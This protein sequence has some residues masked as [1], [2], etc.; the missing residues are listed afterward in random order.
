M[1]ENNTTIKARGSALIPLLVFVAVYLGA[2][3]VLNAMGVDMAF[4]QFPSPVAAMIGVVVAFIMFKGT[5]NEKF[6][7]FAKGCGHEDILTM[8][9][10]YLFA[11][12]FSGVASAMGGG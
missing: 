2:G 9:F 5:M 12:A 4:Y 10:I 11:A 8:C 7:I 6:A 1:N 3:I